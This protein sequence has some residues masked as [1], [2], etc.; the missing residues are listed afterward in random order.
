MSQ[1]LNSLLLDLTNWDL[2]V[3][4]NGQI[5]VATPPYSVPQSVASACK[6]F[7]GDYIYDTTLGIPYFQ[8]ILGQSPPVNV[9]KA[10][11][12]KAALTVPGVSN[13]VVF[14]SGV[15][16]ARQLSGQVQFTDANGQTQVV[17]F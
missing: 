3:D 7:L 1:S 12:T 9:I 10:Q 11:L 14:L 5:A 6:L 17:N 4:N 2:V 13:P 15:T 16:M 8:Q